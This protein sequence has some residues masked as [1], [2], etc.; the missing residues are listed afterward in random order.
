AGRHE[1]ACAGGAAPARCSRDGQGART[2]PCHW[3]RRRIPGL[4]TDRGRRERRPPACS[5]FEPSITSRAVDCA[6]GGVI[7]GPRQMVAAPAGPAAATLGRGAPPPPPWPPR[8]PPPP[9]RNPP[10]PPPPPPPPP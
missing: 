9:S 1:P 6:A 4:R 3:L 5:L 7:D 10:T 8:P 2:L